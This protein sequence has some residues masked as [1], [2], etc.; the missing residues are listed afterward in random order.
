[1]MYS[2]Y[3]EQQHAPCSEL[4]MLD[5]LICATGQLASDWI[6]HFTQQLLLLLNVFRRRRRPVLIQPVLC[7]LDSLQDLLF[8]VFVHLCVIIVDLVLEGICIVFY[9]VTCQ[10][11]VA[12]FL[13]LRPHVSANIYFDDRS[14]YAYVIPS[15]AYCAAS[16]IMRSISS[17]D[18]RALSFVMVM[19]CDLPVPLSRAET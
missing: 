5:W 17:G 11:T 18:R 12:I 4:V 6:R 1:M 13:V 14:R 3:T 10:N 9:A 15:S 7:L 16:A 8:V 19:D 2:R